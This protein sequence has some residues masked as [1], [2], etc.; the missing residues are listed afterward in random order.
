MPYDPQSPRI[1]HSC[2]A[3]GGSQILSI[4]G[5]DGDPKLTTGTL[6]ENQ[7]STY[8]SPDPNVQGLAIFDMT[9]LTWSSQYTAHAPPYEQSALVSQF[10]Q[11]SHQ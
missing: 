6:A 11:D 7:R 4:G 9:N 1:G 3:V 8:D 10:Y 5:R 2:N